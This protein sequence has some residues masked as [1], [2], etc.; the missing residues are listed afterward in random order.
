MR[1]KEWLKANGFPDINLGKGRLSNEQRTAVEAA[2]AKGVRIDGYQAT[3]NVGA[4]A[5]KVERVS[6]GVTTIADIGE[7]TRPEAYWIA[8]AGDQ[9]V[10]NRT[11]CLNCRC[12]LT[13]CKCE[14]P[15]VNL[16]YNKVGVVSFKPR[17]NPEDY[18]VRWW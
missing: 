18:R 10:G 3:T 9:V 12:S 2:V 6:P 16:D 17:P 4:E 1:A 8:T 5:P 7:P 14:S 13:Y 15:R 11:V